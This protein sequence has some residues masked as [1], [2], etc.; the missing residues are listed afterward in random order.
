[1]KNNSPNPGVAKG[2]FKTQPGG[3]GGSC[4]ETPEIHRFLTGLT[5]RNKRTLQTAEVG[6]ADT[7]PFSHTDNDYGSFRDSVGV[8]T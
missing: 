8:A 3:V 6:G 4:V 1:M 5:T 7:R 2:H